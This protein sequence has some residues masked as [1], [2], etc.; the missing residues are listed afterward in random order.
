M[1]YCKEC[2]TSLKEGMKFCKECGTP[3]GE[4]KLIQPARANT[5][6]KTMSKKAKRS[7]IA[8]AI[9]VVLLFAAYKIG[10][11]FTSKERL[12]DRLETALIEKDN[13]AVANLLS[14][15]DKKLEI[16][17]QSV[18]G[19]MKHFKENPDEVNE[20]I[21][22]LHKQST[23]IDQIDNKQANTALLEDW[24]G[25]NDLESIVT[26]KKAGKFLF[27]DNYELAVQPVYLAISTNYKDT[28]LS[29]DGKE[30]GKADKV[31]FEKTYGPYMPGEYKVGATLKT[32]FVDLKTNDHIYLDGTDTKENVDVSLDGQDITLDF[33]W[34]DEAPNLT[35]KLYIN[36]KDVKIDPFKQTT[37]GP[38]LTDGSMTVA[39]EAQLPWGNIKTEQVPIEDS[40]VSINLGNNKDFQQK[41]MDIIMDYSDEYLNAIT[42]GDTSKMQNAASER[43]KGI[44]E[45]IE[46]NKDYDYAYSA[47]HLST[48]FSLDSFGVYADTTQNPDQW[49]MR[50]YTSEKYLADS[51]YGDEEADLEEEEELKDYVL[52]YDESEKKWLVSDVSNSYNDVENGKEIKVEK[53][54]IYETG[55]KTKEASKEVLASADIPEEISTLMDN[56]S[57]DLIEAINSGDFD[58]VS[59]TLLPNSSLY[60]DQK[61]LV[62]SLY[63]KGTTEELVD[64]EITGYTSDGDKGSVSTKE[65]IKI[66]YADGTTKTNVYNWVYAVAK[67]KAG[68]MLLS[69]IKEK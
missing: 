68:D 3:A 23:M 49:A 46:E 61:N 57:N 39:V 26:L 41:I 20:L 15:S 6:K 67:D 28:I 34:E 17:E 37:F 11:V 52:S 44:K 43:I 21:K 33:N 45:E 55:K 22:V 4:E 7:L 2:G 56:Y 1:K 8:G 13:K 5:E 60:N 12:I 62:S 24:L 54:I 58:A 36:G 53:P 14:S 47:S 59:S 16:N 29:V 40:Y 27:F 38:V 18:K 25:A 31:D 66:N 35:G 30:V 63:K 19:F 69:S 50:V 48:N 42:S 9:A 51:Y 64:F 65:T 10:E 32:D